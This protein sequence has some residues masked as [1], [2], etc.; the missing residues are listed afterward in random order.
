MFRKLDVCKR[1]NVSNVVTFSRPEPKVVA[2]YDIMGRPVQYVR[3]NEITIYLYSD[4]STRK[5]I[6][7]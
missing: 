2:M 3:E 1:S 4:G 7:K 6:K 5:I